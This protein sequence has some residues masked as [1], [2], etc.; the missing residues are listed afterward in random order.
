MFYL[1]YVELTS[2][3]E[4]ARLS[5]TVHYFLQPLIVFFFSHVL[6]FESSGLNFRFFPHF[7]F[8]ANPP[9]PELRNK[10]WSP[11]PKTSNHGPRY[12]TTKPEIQT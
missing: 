3:M 4:L 1:I 12:Q 11:T 5:T 8:N 2:E 6:S 7:I 9:N 10:Q